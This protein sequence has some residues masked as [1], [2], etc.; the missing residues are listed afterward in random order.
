MK[1]M[2]RT[3]IE[4]QNNAADGD[5]CFTSGNSEEGETEKRSG[6][7]EKVVAHGVD[8]VFRL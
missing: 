4:G 6:K 1:Q 8:L 3:L 5:G 7:K 2:M